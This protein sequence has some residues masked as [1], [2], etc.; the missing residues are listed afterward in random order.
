MTKKKISM[1]ILCVSF[2]LLLLVAGMSLNSNNAA[3]SHVVI[4]EVCSDNFS[5]TYDEGHEYYDYVELYNP[6]D[7]DTDY[8]IYLSDDREDLHKYLV[9]ESIPAGG[10]LIIW[11]SGTGSEGYLHAGFGVSKDGETLFLSDENDN[12]IDTVQVP[13]LRYDQTYSRKTDGGKSFVTASATPGSSN[14]QATAL[15]TDF[16]DSPVFSLE[17]GFYDVGTELKISAYPWQKI[18]YTLD[19]SVPSENSM[20]YSGSITLQDASDNENYYVNQ[21]MYPT[22]VPPSYKVDKCN[23]VRAIA[24]DYFTGK[25]SEVVTHSYFCGFDNKDI[26][27]NVK[28]ISLVF[29][30]EALFGY[31]SGIFA[32]GKKYDEFKAMGGYENLPDEEVP[33]SVVD[34]NGVGHYRY[35]FTNAFYSGRESEKEARMSVFD[36]DH[37]LSY[38]Q[39]VGVRI[40]GESTRYLYQKSLNLYARDIYDEG[41]TFTEGFFTDNERKVRLRRS[42][43]RIWFV[44]PMM[45]K[46][47]GEL[48][49]LYQDSQMQAVFINGE[50]WGIYN[51]RDQYDA[52]YFYNHL[53]LSESDLW[54]VK[55][56]KAEYGGDDALGSY[57]YLVDFITYSD[58]SVDEI[59]DMICQMVDIDNLID[60]YCALLY[61]DDGD[62]EPRHNQVLWRSATDLGMEDLDGKWRWAVY[63]LDVT[64]KDPE[65]NSFDY[66]RE[67][68]GL[69]LPG[70]LYASD[71]FK[72]KFYN[73]MLELMDTTFSYEH[74]HEY[75]AQYD[76]EYRQQN[77]ASVRRFEGIDYTEED[78]ER[79]LAKLDDFFKRRPEIFREYLEQDMENN[80]E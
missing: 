43:D 67:S 66:F 77:I 45:H 23:V 19:G 63:D 53:G 54:L 76:Q 51:L 57:N 36:S 50:Y 34:S 17:D 29:D 74:M 73:R 30:P 11:L 33:M 56:N 64:C 31:D 80:Q 1:I 24:V 12:R 13:A 8:P 9:E 3:A 48:G 26:Y 69:Y 79:D 70:Y 58:A 44:E 65:N 40:A 49:L 27:D 41:T 42:D 60:Y 47:L 78:Y 68:E 15:Q 46:M 61:F 62:I 22:Y 59:Y 75:L 55:N 25:K 28:V 10:Y 71:E 37:E 6:T 7:A 2:F 5:V 72:E 14:D 39:N 32:L 4:N 16:A 21:S 20:V 52:N 38:T 35:E 18:Y